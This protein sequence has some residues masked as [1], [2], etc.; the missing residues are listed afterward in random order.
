MYPSPPRG[1]VG[2]AVNSATYPS[3]PRGEV[4]GAVNSA[5][6]PSPPRGDVGGD[7][8]F[9]T[10]AI[11]LPMKVEW[12]GH[13]CGCAPL[14]TD[15]LHPV[16]EPGPQRSVAEHTVQPKLQSWTGVVHGGELAL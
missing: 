12:H 15:G 5:T 6:Y 4:G 9:A 11:V 2:G 8:D 14:N 10:S 13:C 7:V 3:P 1:E 16:F